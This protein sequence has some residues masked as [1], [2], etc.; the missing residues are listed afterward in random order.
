MEG[1]DTNLVD[2]SEILL[3]DLGELLLVAFEVGLWK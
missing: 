3:I 2:L 1:K